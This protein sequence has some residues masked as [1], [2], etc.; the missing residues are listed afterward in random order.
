MVKEEDDK[1][2]CSK[3][4]WPTFKLENVRDRKKSGNNLFVK[5]APD[6]AFFLLKIN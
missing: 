2:S 3:G 6:I 1:N 5:C 4:N